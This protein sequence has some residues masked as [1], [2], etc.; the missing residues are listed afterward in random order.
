E[1]TSALDPGVER[2]VLNNIKRRGITC[3]IV[4]HRLSAFRDCNQIV[5]MKNGKIVQ[6]GSH[7]SLMQQEGIYKSFVQTI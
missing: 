2:D 3:I 7:K 4:A 1:A 6:R 5:V